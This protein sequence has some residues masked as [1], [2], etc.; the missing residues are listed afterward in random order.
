MNKMVGVLAR[1]LLSQIFLV[2]ILIQ[3]T[4]ITKN[5]EGYEAYRAYLGHFGLP[6]I[7]AP[8]TILI[9]LLAGA[10]LFLGFKTRF[11]AYVLAVYAV[12]IAFVLKL[13]DP[14]IF[15]QYLAIAGGM[16]VLAINDKTACSVDGWFGKK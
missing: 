1:V 6:G 3:L 8:L 9:Q 15:M 16:L 14:I 11:F 5:P 7:F 12:F 2:H 4:I 13:N 10:A